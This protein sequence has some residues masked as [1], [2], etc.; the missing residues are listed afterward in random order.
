MADWFDT[1]AAFLEI[2]KRRPAQPI[3]PL[4]GLSRDH[5]RGLRGGCGSRSSGVLGQA[6]QQLGGKITEPEPTL[7]KV[8]DFFRARAQGTLGEDCPRLAEAVLAGVSMI[9]GPPQAV[10]GLARLF[11]K[12]TPLAP[13]PSSG[14]L[15]PRPGTG[16]QSSAVGDP[17]KLVEEPERTLWKSRSTW[18][19]V[20]ARFQAD[21]EGALEDIA[22]SSRPSITFFDK[23]T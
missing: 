17:E 15:D 6:A 12:A 20:D 5:T 14:G 4:G 13:T 23:V 1:V 18:Q 16:R 19:P 8:R 10:E 11:A 2:G 7:E 3:P 22:P 21:F 9:S